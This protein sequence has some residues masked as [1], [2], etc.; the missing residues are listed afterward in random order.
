[1][2]KKEIFIKRELN[3]RMDDGSISNY[4]IETLPFETNVII[5]VNGRNYKL[6]SDEVEYLYERGV[7]DFKSELED[8]FNLS[9][10]EVEIILDKI[11]G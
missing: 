11:F 5:E 2:N 7:E 6:H 1:M 8:D 10:V 9:G 3:N 4:N